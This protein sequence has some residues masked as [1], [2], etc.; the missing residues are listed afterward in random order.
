MV[1]L[2]AVLTRPVNNT[3]TLRPR[4]VAL[5]NGPFLFSL[6]PQQAVHSASTMEPNISYDS[7]NKTPQE[8]RNDFIFLTDT[9]D[10]KYV[11]N[12]I[13]SQ[14][15]TDQLAELIDDFNMGRI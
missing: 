5:N 15:N 13:A 6:S 2:G 10:P 3:D 9:F 7:D 12:A 14:L 11:I 8:I 1:P 4:P